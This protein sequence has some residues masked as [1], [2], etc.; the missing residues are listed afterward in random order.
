MSPH[1]HPLDRTASCGGPGLLGA[2]W[3][4]SFA[5]SGGFADGPYGLV[6]VDSSRRMKAVAVVAG[7]TGHRGGAANVPFAAA[8]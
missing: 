5:V 7:I 2:P 6:V 3:R 1:A 4:E 8:I